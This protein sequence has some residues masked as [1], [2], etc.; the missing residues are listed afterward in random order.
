MLQ[1]SKVYK[2]A[3]KEGG[4]KCHPH[5]IKKIR[6]LAHDSSTCHHLL[7]LVGLHVAIVFC[8]HFLRGGLSASRLLGIERV[9]VVFQDN[10]L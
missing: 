9:R 10:E 6:K 7:G 4:K 8:C 5:E 1:V 2:T 3:S